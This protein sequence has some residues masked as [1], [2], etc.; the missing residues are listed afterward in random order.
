MRKP[1][2]WPVEPVEIV[3]PSAEHLDHYCVAHS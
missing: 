2:L 3:R 1:E